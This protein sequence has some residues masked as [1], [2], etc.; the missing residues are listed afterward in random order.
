MNTYE[1]PGIIETQRVFFNTHKTKDLDFR[2]QN[3]KKLKEI[4]QA[5]EDKICLALWEDLHKPKFE[6]YATE[7]G[8]VLQELT[9]QIR[10]L[11]KWSRPKK[12]KT[13]LIHFFSRSYIHSEPY[14][15]VLIFAPWNF[16]F[17][18]LFNPLLG[19]ISAGNCVVMKPSRHTPHVSEIMEEM[20]SSN[21]DPAYIALVKGGKDI[22][23]ALLNEKFDYIFFTGSQRIGRIVM[24]A[25]SRNLTP[26]CLELGGKNPCIVDKD[27]NINLAA[28]RITWSKFF[29]AGQTCVAPDYLLIHKDV[30][31]EMIE[32]IKFFILSFYGS[33]PKKSQ[34]YNHIVNQ[35]NVERLSELIKSGK[36]IFGGE[37]DITQKYVAP[38]LID[39]VKPGDPVMQEEIFGPVL[40]ILEFN[41]IDE[42]LGIINNMPK[43]LSLYIYTNNSKLQKE[44]LHKTSSG[45]GAIN[46]SVI[47]FSN[48]LLPYGGVGESGMG[49]YHGKKSF[50]TFSNLKSIMKKTNLFDLPVRYPPYSSLKLFIAKKFMH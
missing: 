28:K 43:S 39:D 23:K 12:V 13:S 37:V 36:V 16:P 26:V 25:A 47:Q 30:K 49:K 33:E 5:Y 40:P 17:Q 6:A 14:G 19:A 27:A 15:N 42:A 2:I 35:A 22:N 50:E 38:T 29:N 18:L 31:E 32:K 4:I 9:L 21:F 46:D 48:P 1:I 44:I 3:L 24:E 41:H 7:V 11:K 8:L 45:N 34:D 20:I 10:K